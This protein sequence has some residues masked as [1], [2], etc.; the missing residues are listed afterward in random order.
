M[1]VGHNCPNFI[2]SDPARGGGVEGSRTLVDPSACGLQDEGGNNVPPSNKYFYVDMKKYW[3]IILFGL[4]LIYRLWLIYLSPQALI[5]DQVQYH[6]YAMG[7]LKTGLYAHSFRIYGYPLFIALIYK[8][9]GIISTISNLP[10][11]LIQVVLDTSTALLVYFTATRLFD[12]RS[13][14]NIAYIICLFN[15]FTAPFAG[16]LLPKVLIIFLI[17]LFFFLLSFFQQ[18]IGF[19]QLIIFGLLL[20]FSTQV[21]PF[22]LYFSLIAVFI[23]AVVCFK[24]LVNMKNKVLALIVLLIFYFLP[25]SYNVLG[26]LKYFGEFALM[27][28]DNLFIENFYI[29][30]FLESSPDIKLS[31]WDYPPEVRWT[32]ETYSY[33]TDPKDKAGR[34]ARKRMFMDLAFR[35]IAKDPYKFLSWRIKKLWYAWEK[36]TLYP[37]YNP[38]NNILSGFVYWSNIALLAG[39]FV[40]II[41][42]F[43]KIAKKHNITARL[44]FIFSLLLILNTFAVGAA[45]SAQERYSLPAYPI[46]FIYFAYGISLIRELTRGRT[47]GRSSFSLDI[48]KITHLP[49]LQDLS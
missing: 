25:F 43:K 44:F 10:W 13:I 20:G 8:F 5:L 15:P 28:V 16:V 41:S 36:H 35:E 4:G 46:L 45:T 42:F 40:G 47:R 26:N 22:Y 2:L 39:A 17:A 14:A 21:R 33:A 31:I 7:M 27:D 12:R 37:Y 3:I 34:E 24:K 29:G 18:K 6:D 30:L 11:Q 48:R 1:K 23:F 9:T 38:K 19:L 49:L 32:F